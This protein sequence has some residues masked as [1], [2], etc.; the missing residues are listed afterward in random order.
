MSNFLQSL[1][2]ARSVIKSA[3]QSLGATDR[4]A[5][6]ATAAGFNPHRTQTPLVN[7]NDHSYTID[8]RSFAPPESFGGG[9]QGDN[10]GFTT[11]PDATARITSEISID[12]DDQTEIT[13]NDVSAFS[14]PSIHHLLPW[15]ERTEIPTVDILH[16]NVKHDGNITT[17]EI[18]TKHAGK[19][20]LLY[21]GPVGDSPNIAG[22]LDV[23]TDLTIVDNRD[24]NIMTINGTLTGDNFP[25]TESFI[26][27][28]SGQ[29]LFL[30]TGTP[31]EFASPITALP[32]GGERP[33]A[34]ISLSVTTDEQGNF[35]SVTADGNEY[36]ISEWNEIFE[37]QEISFTDP[38]TDP[39]NG[40]I[41]EVRE[42]AGE[43]A[44]EAVEAYNEVRD[45]EGFFGTT[46][47]VI[48]GAGEII[49]ETGEGIVESGG[50]FIIDG[51]KNTGAVVGE[52]IDRITPWEGNIPWDGWLPG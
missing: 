42:G 36:T 3:M 21:L 33:I 17:I 45:A 41:V 25:A 52:G 49:Y 19:D 50:T 13:E 1:E 8:T 18:K 16:Q 28:P 34:D 23:Y 10:R 51:T 11:D 37:S 22:S 2:N 48:E 14:D 27:D 24:T 35:V 20:A 44:G 9:F 29:S 43:V 26:T 32:H 47:E 46:G 31:G 7:P 39:F 5:S 40:A 30:G 12:T 38:I 4:P 6:G 15:W